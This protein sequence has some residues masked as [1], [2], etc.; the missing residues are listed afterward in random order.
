M[1]KFYDLAK[2]ALDEVGNML[3]RME[4]SEKLSEISTLEVAIRKKVEEVMIY[5]GMIPN[6]DASLV[7]YSRRKAIREGALSTADRVREILAAKE[8][9]KEEEP[10]EGSTQVSKTVKKK[11]TAKTTKKGSKKNG[12]K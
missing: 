4:K 5:T 9:P 10:V 6:K 1:G 11:S 3:D 12:S 2:G 8:E 7:S